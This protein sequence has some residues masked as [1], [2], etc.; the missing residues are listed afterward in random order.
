M[1]RP[2]ENLHVLLIIAINRRSD[3][4]YRIIGFA[5]IPFAVGAD[6]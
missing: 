5:N 6:T 3:K 2:T 1:H 4:D